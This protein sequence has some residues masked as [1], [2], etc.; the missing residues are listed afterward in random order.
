MQSEDEKLQLLTQLGCTNIQ[1]K[2][3]LAL[4]K[5][6]EAKVKAISETSN[7]QRTE[8][9]RTLNELE[10]KGL[11]EKEITAP[12]KFMATSLR[13]GLKILLAKQSRQN[14]ANRER[15]NKFLL[16]T[17][18]VPEET[19]ERNEYRLIM[20]EGKGRLQ[21]IIKSEHDNAEKSVAVLSTLQRWLQILDF[22]LGNYMKAV[23]RGV[24]Y[25]VVLESPGFDVAFQEGVQALLARPGFE[26]RLSR[27]PLATNAAIF[28]DKEVTINFFQGKPIGES[29][30]I[31]TNHP[32]FIQMCKDHF[33]QIWK[34]AQEYKLTEEAKNNLKPI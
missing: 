17:P 8:V 15:V 12:Y 10:K 4:L 3:Y 1:A 28:D 11:V 2:I 18:D 5:L 23:N 25:R 27:G 33:K 6:G 7:I 21:Q 34:S 24:N 31:W 30:I 22:S 16:K 26:L 9:Y 14:E 29:P 19:L 20:V 32:S 13:C